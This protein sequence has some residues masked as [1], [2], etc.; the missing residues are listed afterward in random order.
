[1]RRLFLSTLNLNSVAALAA[2]L[3][4][5]TGAGGRP[6]IEL[7]G[8]SPFFFFP[9]P[10]FAGGVTVVDSGDI[11][12]YH[13]L[14]VIANRRFSSGLSFEF[15]Y[16]FSRSLDTRSFDPTFTT[17]ATGATQTAS[18]TPY[19]IHNRRL[20]YAR[21]DFDRRHV[22]QG[23]AVYDL[24][25]GRGRRF[26]SD[27]HSAIERVIGGWSLTGSI[28]WESGRP[29][30]VYSGSNTF[31][32]LVQSPANCSGCTPDMI[33][34]ILDPAVGTE[35]YF[36]LQQRGTL[37]LDPANRRGIF[38]V[39]DPGKLGNLG[40][41]F[42]T[43]PGFFNT[44]LAIGKRTR[45]SERHSIEYRFEMQNVTNTPSFGL[46]ESSVITSTLFGRSRGN[47]TSGSRK[48]QMAL[49]YNF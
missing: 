20:N 31:S 38:S 19:D 24:P 34:R 16:T 14:Q 11:S 5:R 7:S 15:G 32:S 27:V 42:F 28:V 26:A 37:P 47:T 12:N 8:F 35:F 45:V 39:P 36:D 40:R 13:G 46:P 30:T 18:N 29:F 49:K 10:Q 33:R 25:F 1:V 3:A 48:I 22:F 6:V 2:T 4:R 21:S 41:N 17:A 44:N 23:G 43:L 9:Y